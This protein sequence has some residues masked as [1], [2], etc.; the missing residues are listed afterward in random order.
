MKT[1]SP[2]Q[3]L[4]AAV[5]QLDD[6]IRGS[7]DESLADEYEDNLFERA[8][9][10]L[11][12]ELTF[13]QGLGAAFRA[14]DARGTLDVWVTAADV[15]RL[16]ASDLRLAVWDFD[17]A[18]PSLPEVPSDVDLVITRILVDLRGVRRV[19]ADIVAPDGRLLKT[20]RDVAFDPVDGAVYA[21]CEADL[22]RAAVATKTTTRVYSVEDSGRRLLLEF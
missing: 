3:D 21:C 8:L 1:G 15:E 20:M 18:S 13:R 7:L 4:D 19:E 14:M 5:S 6:Y 10:G 9:G 17:P 11:A 2:L 16:K 22:A 12:A